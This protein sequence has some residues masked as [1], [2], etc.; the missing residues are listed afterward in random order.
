MWP[1]FQRCLK[2]RKKVFFVLWKLAALKSRTSCENLSRKVNEKHFAAPLTTDE[3]VPLS[4]FDAQQ[5]QCAGS[6]W[7]SRLE[8]KECSSAKKVKQLTLFYDC[9]HYAATL[10]CAIC[11]ATRIGEFCSTFLGF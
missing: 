7:R 4:T 2:V 11:H 9:V 5:L 3:F 6:K 8:S 1:S 10:Y